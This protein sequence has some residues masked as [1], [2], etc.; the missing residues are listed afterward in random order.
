MEDSHLLLLFLP[1][2]EQTVL[3]VDP[4][5]SVASFVFRRVKNDARFRIT[6]S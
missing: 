3:A 4:V 2:I 1:K 6:D 5:D